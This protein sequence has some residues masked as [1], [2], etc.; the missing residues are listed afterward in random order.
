MTFFNL[1][2]RTPQCSQK[3]VNDLAFR[4]I[5]AAIE[6]QKEM[7]AGMKE[8]IYEE[9]L[10]IEL[11][12]RGIPFKQQFTYR[13]YYKGRQLRTKSTTDLIVDDLIVVELKA[14]KEILPIH[15]VQALN[16]INVLGLPKALILNF[17]TTNIATQG[18]ISIVNK[19][20]AELW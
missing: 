7:P 6:V 5:G 4:V 9:C 3:M 13:P 17:N 11:A 12:T 10:M 2:D 15:R 20:Y 16:Y 8:A 18:T 14:V 1:R 19:V